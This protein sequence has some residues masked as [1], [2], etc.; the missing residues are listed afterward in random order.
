MAL[1]V[2]IKKSL[3]QRARTNGFGRGAAEPEAGEANG[4]LLDVEF[5]ARAGVTILFG[6]SGSGKTTTLKSIAGIL[7][8]DAGRIAVGEKALFDS[9]HAID[10]PIRRRGV[11][12]VFQHLALFPHLSARENVEFGMTNTGRR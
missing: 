8:P 9:E 5:V 6:A 4:F 1:S 11:G 10:L 12:Y 3:D 2:N 7:R